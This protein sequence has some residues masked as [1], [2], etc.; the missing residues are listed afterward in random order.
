MFRDRVDAGRQLAKELMHYANREDVLILGIPRGGVPVAFE[1]A[2][3]LRAALD[4]VL[5]RK[6][7][8]PGQEELA[9]GA[10]A[11]GGVRVLNQ[12]LIAELGISD[13]QVADAIA[14][15]EAE[16][17]RRERSYRGSRPAISVKG[18]I[19]ILVDDGIATGSSM[20]AA[21]DA[22]RNLEPKK[23]VVADQLRQLIQMSKLGGLLMNLFVL[24]SPS[25]S[26]ASVSSTRISPRLRTRKSIRFSKALLASL[27]LRASQGEPA[28]HDDKL[29]GG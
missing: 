21:V 23:I 1:V 4:I 22:L 6:L 17:Q 3:A 26:L 12:Q 25:G 29:V 10:I 18:K 15:Q 11:S 27:W 19:V 13:E 20:L 7:G 16:L 28:R 5:V 8:T 24:T 14:T 9:M 2:K